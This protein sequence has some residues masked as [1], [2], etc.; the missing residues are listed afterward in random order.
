MRIKR[1]RIRRLGRRRFSSSKGV[2]SFS[3][4]SGAAYPYSQMKEEPGTGFWVHKSESDGVWNIADF[5]RDPIVP[6]EPQKLKHQENIPDGAVAA[7]E[8]L[9]I[10]KVIFTPVEDYTPVIVIQNVSNGVDNVVN[11]LD[12][13][14]NSIIT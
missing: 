3:D 8:Q 5:T 12:N 4:R 14:V 13:V 1:G 2:T 10:T 7:V 11:G 6:S 9:D